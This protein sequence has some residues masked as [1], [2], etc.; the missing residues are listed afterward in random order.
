M[1]PINLKANTEYC[2][3]QQACSLSCTDPCEYQH[4]NNMPLKYGSIQESQPWPSKTPKQA[5]SFQN[6]GRCNLRKNEE[7]ERDDMTQPRSCKT[8]LEIAHT[9][10]VSLCEV[11]ITSPCH[12]L[13]YLTLLHPIRFQCTSHQVLGVSLAGE[14]LHDCRQYRF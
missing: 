5:N 14:Q 11:L 7:F 2:C 4:T 3:A 6:V 10:S 9:L 12:N 8:E 1:K 13:F